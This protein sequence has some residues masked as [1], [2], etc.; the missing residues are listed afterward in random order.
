MKKTDPVEQSNNSPKDKRG[1]D[2]Y[3]EFLDI[4]LKINRLFYLLKLIPSTWG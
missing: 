1:G 2:V 4:L 3:E